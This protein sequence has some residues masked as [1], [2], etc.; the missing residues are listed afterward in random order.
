M[1]DP[2][3]IERASAAIQTLTADMQAA[4]GAIDTMLDRADG[5]LA[6]L[7]EITDSI[8]AMQTQLNHRTR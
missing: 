5:L 1:I 6:R 7:I 3:E 2:A 4:S 8:S